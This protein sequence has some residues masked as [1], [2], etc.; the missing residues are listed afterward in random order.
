MNN[1]YCSPNKTSEYVL[2]GLPIICSPQQSLKSLVEDN[3]IGICLDYESLEN[4]DLVKIANQ[5][6]KFIIDLPLYNNNVHLKKEIFDYAEEAKKLR[7]EI[8]SLYAQP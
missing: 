4:Y 5:I 2:S 6:N 3:G 7:M 1:K 8:H